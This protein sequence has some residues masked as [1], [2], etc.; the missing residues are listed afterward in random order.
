MARIVILGSSN[1]VSNAE[2][3]YTHFLL[4]GE[5]TTPI[6]VDAGSNPLGKIQQLGVPDD[7][8]RHIILT[9]FHADHVSGIPNMFMHMWQRGRKEPLELIGLHHCL[10]RVKDV[11]SFHSWEDWPGFFP[12]TFRHVYQRNRAPVLENEDFKITAWPVQHFNVPN[13]GLRVENKITG[14]VLAYS[15]DTEPTP[16]LLQIADQADIFVHEAA[17]PPPG[18]STAT[19]AGEMATNAKA[20]SLYLIHYEVWNADPDELVPEAQQTFKGP[21][22]LCK[23]MDEYEF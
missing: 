21:V 6:L 12:V 1:A 11:L 9:H 8:L 13:I 2:H 14:K 4:F 15:C 19:L 23:D 18:H 22:F 5:K 20:Q 7:A 16:A 3:D 10:N 17:G